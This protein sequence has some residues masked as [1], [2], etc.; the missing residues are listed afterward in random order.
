MEFNLA[1]LFECVAAQVPA[2]EAVVWGKTRLTFRQLDDRA[3]QLAHGLRAMGI[4][5]GC[6]VGILTYSR[7]EYLETM[8]AAFKIRAVPINVN[9]RYV[10][11]ELAYLFDN[12]DLEVLVLESSFAPVVVGILER[13]PRLAHLIV[14][15]DGSDGASALPEAVAYEDVIAAESS[16]ADFPARS[17][18]DVYIAYTGGTTGMPK[19]VVWRQEDIF[20]ATMTPGVAIL[21]PEEIAANA[22]APV[23]PRLAALAE[24]GVAVPDIYV[25][26]SLGPLMHVSGHWSAW[27]AMLSGGRTVLHPTRQMDAPT[28]LDVVDAERV[29]MLTIVGDSM[30]LPLVEALESDPG[31]YDTSSVL[32]LGSGGSIMSASVKE[33]LF[34]GFPSVMVMVEAIGSSESPSQA[35]SITSRGQGPSET[36]RF[37]PKEGTTVFDDELRPVEA[38]SGV[39]GRLATTG[40]VPIGYYNDPE[41]SAKAFV[42]VDGVRWALP[43]DMASIEADHSIRLLGRGSMC[44]NTGGEKVYPEEVEAVLKAHDRIVDAV[45]V[46]TPDPRFGERVA[47]VVEAVP[48][49]PAPTLDELQEYCRAH[50]AGHKVP[51]QLFI[52]D[53]VPRSPSGKLDYGWAKGIAAAGA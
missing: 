51:R 34:A 17:G 52:V 44:I 2:R 26:Y 10:A 5:P 46:G 48:N 41:K 14:V 13:L 18:D 50:L 12:A 19:G 11:D 38:G 4:G 30:G 45:I 33:R 21:R 42:T 27:G 3:T 16:L 20:F 23:H 24:S 49:S 15:D 7:P 28:V 25:S 40:R 43:G 6:H 35:L 47:A 9:Y 31:R 8:V 32:M 53:K 37:D 22:V 39:V 36:L 1:D 29:T